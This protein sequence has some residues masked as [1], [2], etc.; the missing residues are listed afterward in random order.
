MIE[1]ERTITV[2]RPVDPVVAYLADFGHTEEWDPGTVRCR[3]LDAGPVREGARWANVSRFR[4]RE[5]ELTYRLVRYRSDHLVFTGEN[6]TVTATD[7]LRLREE[8]G[9][10]VITYRA[11]LRFKG[12]ARLVAPLLRREFERLA[13]AVERSLPEVLGRG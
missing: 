12:A 7:D 11:Q 4:G 10:T 1:V 3:R 13:D 9:R 5:S 6:R 2:E 8:Q